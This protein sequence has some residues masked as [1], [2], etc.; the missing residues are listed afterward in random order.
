MQ[1]LLFSDPGPSREEFP[2][3]PDESRVSKY[4]ESLSQPVTPVAAVCDPIPPEA[5]SACLPYQPEILP[6]GFPVHQH[7]TGRV[8]RFQQNWYKTFPW[9]HVSGIDGV[10]CFYC[11]KYIQLCPDKTLATKADMAF[12][13]KGFKNWKKAIERFRNHEKSAAHAQAVFSHD[14]QK[15]PIER[16][17]SKIKAEEQKVALESLM[18]IIS[19]LK[20]L[21]RQGLAIRGHTNFEGNFME[22]LK[23]RSEDK[24]SLRQWL[25]RE[26]NYTHPALQNEIIQI[27]GNEI[28]AN[29]TEKIKLTNPLIYSVI[30]DGTQDISGDEQESVCVRWC[31]DNLEPQE[32]FMGFYKTG[33]TCGS[34]IASL[35]CDALLRLQL[36]LANLRG[37]TYDG[38]GNMSGINKGVQTIIIEKQPLADYVHCGAHCCNLV[39][40]ASCES[41]RTVKNAMEWAH[42]LGILFSN[43][44]AKAVFIHIHEDAVQGPIGNTAKIKPLCPTR[45]LCRRSQIK[46]ILNRYELV[47]KTLSELTE[48]G[49][50]GA[51]GLLSVFE[52]G[53]TYVGLVMGRDVIELLEILNKCFQ[54]EKRTIAGLYKSVEHIIDGLNGLRTNEKFSSVFKQ[55]NDKISEL[56]LEELKLPRQKKVPKRIGGTTDS[57]VYHQSCEEYYRQQYFE[58]I[59]TAVAGLQNRIL[60]QPGVKKQVLL[61]NVLLQ[62]EGCEVLA[63]YPEIDTSSFKVEIELFLQRYKVT[64]L[65]DARVALISM[66]K[67]VRDLFRNVESLV[68]LLLVCP[69]SSCEAE[70]SF[71][72]LRKLKT[73]L[74]S[75][76]TQTRLNHVAVCYVHKKVLDDINNNK[77]AKVFISNVDARR[78]VFGT[79]YD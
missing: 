14:Q 5:D 8:L 65:H 9:L 49:Y 64:C 67:E 79:V 28:V 6:D 27:L 31:D 76:M 68:R 72:A 52:D 36:P 34:D 38:A 24:P 4:L 39:M 15:A 43:T 29:I 2:L 56:G 1:Y 35:I 60:N 62:K 53:A 17:L 33:V 61:E 63:P 50:G 22:L 54:G 44:K 10:S 78:N 26:Q 18:V 46:E 3:P 77:I 12:S 58:V 75:T 48:Q 30:C 41:S 71:S 57:H 66:T 20:Y 13:G 42:Q 40:K 45:W 23:V 37:Q 73:Y 25:Q 19:T 69:A 51:S 70:R 21:V 74:R 55:C 16:Q 11:T 7:L 32:S 47:I 59:D